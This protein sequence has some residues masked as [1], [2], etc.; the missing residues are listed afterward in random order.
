MN[1]TLG[2]ANL[3]QGAILHLGVN[4]HQGANCAYKRGFKTTG[5]FSSNN[6]SLRWFYPQYIIETIG[7]FKYPQYIEIVGCFKYLQHIIETIGC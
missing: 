6:I 1:A 5:C 3:L 7:C 2:V 4:L